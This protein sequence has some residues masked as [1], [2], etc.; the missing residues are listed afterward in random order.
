V[1]QER[2][3]KSKAVLGEETVEMLLQVHQDALW[4]LENLGVR[5]RQ[6]EIQQVFEALAAEGE[7]VVYDER[8]Y[9]TSGL[10]EKCLAKVPGV[11]DFFVALNSCFSGG[12]APYG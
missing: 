12:T 7:A 10:V 5:C 2:M 8:I 11:S 9:L 1:N 6:P 4:I 3:E